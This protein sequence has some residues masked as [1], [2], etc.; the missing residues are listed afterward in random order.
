MR[1]EPRV[2][3]HSAEHLL[4]VRSCTPVTAYRV[5]ITVSDT[6]Q[7]GGAFLVPAAASDPLPLRKSYGSE[8]AMRAV[9]TSLSLF[10][11]TS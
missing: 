9:Q 10:G 6:S 1:D 8:V 3:D 2:P 5:P 11:V 7:R 4:K